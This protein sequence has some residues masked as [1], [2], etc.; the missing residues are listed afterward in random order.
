MIQELEAGHWN[1]ELVLKKLPRGL[2]A[3]YSVII[4][5]II[6]LYT[7]TTKLTCSCIYSN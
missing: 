6:R 4:D 7:A 1:V 2:S 3:M 5:R